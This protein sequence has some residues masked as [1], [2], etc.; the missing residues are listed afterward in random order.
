M[1]REA[2]LEREAEQR[3]L[4]EERERSGR[5][6]ALE[7]Q[8]QHPRRRR[9]RNKPDSQ[10]EEEGGASFLQRYRLACVL[11]VVAVSLVAVSWCALY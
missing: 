5:L 4:E 9:R 3:R 11:V 10:E 2:G 6:E 8:L 7:R 1:E